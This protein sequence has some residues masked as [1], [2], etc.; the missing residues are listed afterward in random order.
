MGVY[1]YVH[2]KIPKMKNESTQNPNTIPNSSRHPHSI[3]AIKKIRFAQSLGS[4]SCSEYSLNDVRTHSIPRI[5]GRNVGTL[6]KRAFGAK[7][8]IFPDENAENSKNCTN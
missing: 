2:G 5:R 1:V 6:R 3:S 4:I 7:I 8:G